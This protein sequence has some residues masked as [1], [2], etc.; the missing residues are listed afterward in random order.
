MPTRYIDEFQR[1]TRGDE[2]FERRLPVLDPI[3]GPQSAAQDVSINGQISL[4]AFTADQNNL[5][6]PNGNSFRLSTDGVARTI[7]GVANVST[8]RVIY[9]LNVAGGANISLANDSASSTEQNRILTGTGGTV[10]MQPDRAAILIYDGEDTRW[11][12]VAMT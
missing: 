10:A 2:D 4:D 8:G 5:T 6:L 11:R 9:I 12:L 7:T 3:T 1:Y